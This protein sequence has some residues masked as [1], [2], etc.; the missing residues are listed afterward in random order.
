MLRYS[1]ILPLETLPRVFSYRTQAFSQMNPALSDSQ[2][3]STE[4]L[5]L[6]EPFSN[7][8]NITNNKTKQ[9]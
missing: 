6:K 5:V 4:Q 1:S 9:T 3:R 2:S 7:K 8:P